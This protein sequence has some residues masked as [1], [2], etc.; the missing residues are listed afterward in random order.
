M[1]ITKKNTN[2]YTSVGSKSYKSKRLPKE[3]KNNYSPLIMEM[4]KHATQAYQ[5]WNL[6]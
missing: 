6:Q 2:M 3:S 5:S 4:S 1:Q